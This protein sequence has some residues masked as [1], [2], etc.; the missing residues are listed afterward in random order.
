MLVGYARVSTDEQTL[1]LQNDALQASECRQIFADTASGAK[2]DRRGLDDALRFVR[3]GDALHRSAVSTGIL[4]RI[5]KHETEEI[6]WAYH[7]LKRQNVRP[8]LQ[9]A[10]ALLKEPR[11]NSNR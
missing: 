9:S 4:Q 10:C 3:P 1:N 11:A 5:G 6:F 8:V 7:Q 2:R